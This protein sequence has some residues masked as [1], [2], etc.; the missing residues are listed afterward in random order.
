MLGGCARFLSESIVVVGM[1]VD[2]DKVNEAKYQVYR[3]RRVSR[4]DFSVVSA[5]MLHSK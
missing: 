3:A 2:A 4:K 5:S 1:Y